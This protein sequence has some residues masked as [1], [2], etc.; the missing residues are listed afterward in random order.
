MEKSISMAD[1]VFERIEDA[2]LSG[3]FAAGDVV[4]ELKLCKMLDV[5]RTPVREALTR[6]RQEGLVKESGKGAIVV[7]VS[8]D[9]LFD[10]YDVRMRIEGLAAAK[11]AS[12]ITEEQLKELGE[13]LELQE[14][15]TAKNQPDSIKKLDSQFHEQ[16]YSYCQSRTLETLLSEL[17]RKVKRYRKT[18]V[19][20]P[21]RAVLAVKEHRE[22][23][24][25]IAAHNAVLAEEL[26]EKH[27]RN[28]KES[29]L[30]VC[31]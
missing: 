10:I 13:T 18:S 7:G 4:S 12:V 1:I 23:F 31:R 3:E 2:I 21:E 22:I 29:I 28:A 9:D 11:C 19:S 25:A 6:L 26:V 5:S 17:H 30:K 20:N 16:I 24:E 14:F 8:K 27:I 15:Y